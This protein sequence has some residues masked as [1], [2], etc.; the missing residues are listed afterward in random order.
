[1]EDFNKDGYTD[2]FLVDHGQENRLINGRW[3]GGYLI[4]YYGSANG[5]V[6]QNFPGITDKKLFYHHAD[7][8]DYDNDG[9]LDIISQRWSSAT[10]RVASDNTVSILKNNQGKFEIINLKKLSSFTKWLWQLFPHHGLQ[11][12][13]QFATTWHWHIFDL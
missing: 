6:K 9:D 5:F 3:E 8:G 4:M 2:I 10:E 7:V 12:M 13:T 1:M 11:F